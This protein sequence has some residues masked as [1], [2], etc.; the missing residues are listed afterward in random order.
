MQPTDDDA[1]DRLAGVLQALQ[2]ALPGFVPSLPDGVA[3]DEVGPT[4]RFE[5]SRERLPV[6]EIPRLMLTLLG[7]PS[8]GPGEKMEWAIRF[9]VDGVACTLSSEKFG[10]Q[11]YVKGII[12]EAEAAGLAERVIGRLDRAQRVLERDVLRPLAVEQTELGNVTLVNQYFHLRGAYT[13]FRDGARNAYEGNG[14]LPKRAP[15]GGWHAMIEQR[16]GFYNTVAMVS[17][18]F[19]LL[20]HILVLALPFSLDPPLKQFTGAGR[21]T[22]IPF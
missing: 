19:S 11:L 5:V 22:R 15:G 18:Y 8:Y 2:R 16:E 1:T 6:P 12:A 13:Y 20:E 14:R 9:R 3:G 4:C 17:A 21:S 10:L 7:C